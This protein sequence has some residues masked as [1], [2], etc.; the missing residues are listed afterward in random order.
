MGKRWTDDDR[1]IV[2]DIWKKPELLKNAADRLPDRTYASIAKEACKLGLGRKTKSH[3]KLIALL[4]TILADGVPRSA[5]ELAAQTDRARSHVFETLMSAVAR[6][7][8]HIPGYGLTPTHRRN[9]ACF[10]IG[11]GK[12]LARPAAETP[13][14]RG[15]RFRREVDKLEYSFKRKQYTLNRKIKLG[16]VQRDALTEAFFGK[17]AA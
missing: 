12:S 11:K 9:E 15:R 10:K 7:E 17:A 1:E 4:K 3:G 5:K 8:L 16:G 14:E 6:G 2:R 13:V